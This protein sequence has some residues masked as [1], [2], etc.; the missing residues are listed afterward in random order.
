MF[1][2]SLTDMIAGLNL[3]VATIA[4]MN[5]ADLAKLAGDLSSHPQRDHAAT[6]LADW[7]KHSGFVR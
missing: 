4:G 7:L 1:S 5:P 3:N 2:R 6:T